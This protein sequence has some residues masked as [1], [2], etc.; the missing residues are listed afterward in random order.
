M[1]IS[2]PS[3]EIFAVDVPEVDDFTVDFKYMYFVPD[4]QTVETSGMTTMML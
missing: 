2:L 3:R 1:S 4:E